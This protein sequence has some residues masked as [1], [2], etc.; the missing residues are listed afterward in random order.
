M[1]KI[2]N[3]D[4][5]IK[6]DDNEELI[7]RFLPK[8]SNCHS[9]NDKPPT[10]WGEV[11]KVYYSYKIFKK[12]KDDNSTQEMFR[13]GCDECSVIDEVAARI[14]YII[15]GKKTVTINYHNKEYIIE[16][17]NKEIIPYGDG[18]S[19][20]INETTNILKEK[21]YEIILWKY[22][23]IGYRFYIKKNKLKEF[24]EFLYKCCEYMLAHGDPI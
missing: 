24:G 21:I 6:E 15:E 23:G 20:I 4:F 10:K 18:V 12:W 22:N 3:I 13:C 9:F 19:W 7:F 17:L 14:K 5:V 11:Y 1:K 16:L 8:E 2:N